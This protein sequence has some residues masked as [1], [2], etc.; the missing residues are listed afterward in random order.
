MPHPSE[1]NAVT[2]EARREFVRKLLEKRRNVTVAE[3]WEAGRD[4][5]LYVGGD[6]SLAKD[7]LNAVGRRTDG[8]WRHAHEP[9]GQRSRYVRWADYWN[10]R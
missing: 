10:A 7:D 5:G 8:F 2:Q 9:E 1:P 3:A 4:A 6:G